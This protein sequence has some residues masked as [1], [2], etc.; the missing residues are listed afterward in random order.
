MSTICSGDAFMVDAIDI[1]GDCALCCCKNVPL[2]LG[3]VEVECSVCGARFASDALFATVRLRR[4][5]LGLS[6][7]EMA[8]KIGLAVT[9]IRHY[10]KNWPSKRYWEK[11]KQMV[12]A[13]ATP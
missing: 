11:T 4:K 9:T 10:E 8:E 12:L 3:W 2:K 6:V 13:E 1:T 7:K 5:H